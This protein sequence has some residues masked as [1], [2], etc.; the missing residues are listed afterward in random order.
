[1]PGANCSIY[2][3]G[4]SRKHVGI[5]IFKIPTKDDELSKKTREAWV[6]L[7]TRDR[8]VDASLR[9]QIHE[10]NI[11]ICEKHFEKDL[12]SNGIMYPTSLC[13][14]AQKRKSNAP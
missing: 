6:R 10:N 2:G 4:T 13:Q 12:V 5:S 7:V 9:K 14:N 11:H 8:E 1:M 3:C